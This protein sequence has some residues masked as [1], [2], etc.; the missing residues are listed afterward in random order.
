MNIE[1]NEEI[2]QLII[3]DSSLT[4]ANYYV[5]YCNMIYTLAIK[6]LL[7]NFDQDNKHQKA[8][9][10]VKEFIKNEKKKENKYIKKVEEW[11]NASLITKNEINKKKKMAKANQGSYLVIAFQRSF[12]HLYNKT[13]FKN[14]LYE[15]IQEG[16]DT[17]TN[18]A[19]VGGLLG[20]YHG[21]INIPFE[22]IKKIMNCKPGPNSDE[23]IA[24]T[25][26]DFQAKLYLEKDIVLNIIENSP[27]QIFVL[28]NFVLKI[29]E[30]F[31]QEKEEKNDN[32]NNKKEKKKNVKENILSILANAKKVLNNKK[33]YEITSKDFDKKFKDSLFIK[34]EIETF[35]IVIGFQKEK[36]DEKN[37][38]FKLTKEQFNL[39]IMSYAER[40]FK[41]L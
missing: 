31:D 20:C 30:K 37:V 13:P 16:N 28:E 27:K 4:H 19:I 36:S 2:F 9:N 18:A 33:D 5:Y 35:L 1:S 10:Y 6:Y 29:K 26:Q 3:Q 7:N 34:T 15:V 32:E 23:Q 14:A 24:K 40:V 38:K 8:I 41:E 22:F 11:L 12:Y 21:I 39:Y 25:R 17:D